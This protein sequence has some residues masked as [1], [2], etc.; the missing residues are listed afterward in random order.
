MVDAAVLLLTWRPRGETLRGDAMR[1]SGGLRSG[2]GKLVEW[3]AWQVAE[4][5]AC[6]TPTPRRAGLQVSLQVKG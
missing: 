6:V 1:G 2:L 5:L 3:V 4:P